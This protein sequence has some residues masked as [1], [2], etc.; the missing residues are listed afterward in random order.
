M[1][2]RIV[3]ADDHP[4]LRAAVRASVEKVWPGHEIVE[5][6]DCAEARAA[7][8]AGGVEL[9]TL[10]LHM[11]DSTGLQTLM[12]FRQDFPAMPIVVVSASEDRRIVRN[13]REIGASGFIPKS[14]PLD[15]MREALAAVAAGDLWFPEIAEEEPE[16]EGGDAVARLARLTPA[17]RRILALVA[18]GKLNKQIAHEMDITEATVKAH[19]T[20]IFR[21]LGVINRTQAVLIAHQLDAG[22]PGV[23]G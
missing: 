12:A 5:A 19:M 13:A 22:A 17:Q 8:E 16:D 11:A 9:M 23:E 21:R 14:A 2:H 20:A 3:I 6:A 4:L 7:A 10:D 1:A 18:E 15:V